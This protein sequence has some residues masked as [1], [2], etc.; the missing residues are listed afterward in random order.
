MEKHNI[1]TERRKKY[2]SN[3]IIMYNDNNIDVA[4]TS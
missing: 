1:P 4:K 2:N 3:E